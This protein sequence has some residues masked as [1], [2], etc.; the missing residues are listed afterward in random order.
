LALTQLKDDTALRAAAHAFFCAAQNAVIT[1]P[2]QKSEVF[3]RGHYRLS[4][5]RTFD[6]DICN[7]ETHAL[8]DRCV[9]L[10]GPSVAHEEDVTDLAWEYADEGIQSDSS[11]DLNKTFGNFATALQQWRALPVRYL[12]PN[13]VIELATGTSALV[14]GPVSV[15]HTDEIAH[16]T[17]ANWA[18][19]EQ[20]GIIAIGKLGLNFVDGRGVFGMTPTCWDVTVPASPRAQSETALWMIDVAISLIRLRVLGIFPFAHA[21]GQPE[22]KSSGPRNHALS[23]IT[24]SGTKISGGSSRMLG[25]YAFDG[26]TADADRVNTLAHRGE[27][28]FSAA[29]GSVAER[30]QQGLGWLTRARTA[31]DRPERFLYFFTALEALLSTDDK[32]AP[33][34]QTISRHASVLC[35]N[36]NW[37]RVQI[38]A[39]IKKLYEI[40][41]ELVHKGKRGVSTISVMRIQEIVE[42]LF[43]TVLEAERL[44]M[45][46]QAFSAELT[47]SSFGMEW[48]IVHPEAS[49]RP[50]LGG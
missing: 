12:L 36:D 9:K 7:A 5:G 48:P 30:V 40:R 28:I 18:N 44:E 2:K 24:V 1:S 31:H 13:Q 3:N 33:V 19:P 27:K 47:Q 17:G 32:S 4:A 10:L 49:A 29:R 25:T 6:L 23:A 45:K 39:E 8:V 43:Y 41:S 37:T 26:A 22:A 14:V 15:R 42:F 46:H 20:H 35:T 50:E 16:E 38:A 11:V 21:F 34:I